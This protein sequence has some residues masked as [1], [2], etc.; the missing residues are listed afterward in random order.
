MSLVEGGGGL[1][2]G[3]VCILRSLG[4]AAFPISFLSMGGVCVLGQQMVVSPTD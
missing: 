1:S 4:N 3:E 2:E